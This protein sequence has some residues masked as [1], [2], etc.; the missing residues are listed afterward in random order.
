MAYIIYKTDGTVLLTLAV[1]DVDISTT[2]LDLIGK[3]VD[4]YGQ[5]SNNN[6]VRLLTNF[7]YETEPRSPQ[8][9][10]LW[11]DT[12]NARLNVYNGTAF[13]PPYGVQ[14]SGTTPTLPSEGDLWYDTINSQLKIRYGSVYKVIGPDV[15]ALY[16]KFGISTAPT[17]LRDADTDVSQDVGV[18][19][20]YGTAVGLL[21]D[22]TFNMTPADSV[23]YFNTSTTSTVVKGITALNDIDIKGDL[24]INGIRQIAP[25]QTLTTYYDVSAFGDPSDPTNL[26][27][28]N[29]AIGSFLAQVFSTATNVA[30]NEIAYPLYSDARVVCNYNSTP[31]VRR[32]QL[33]IDPLHPTVS[34]WKSYDVYYNSGIGALTNIVVI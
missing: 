33:I 16:G 26:E 6:L 1:G 24:Y 15:S 23:N 19:Y 2:S 10:Q 32:F 8:I 21:T 11:Y 20:S 28:G 3:N 12:T 25:I 5:Y 13:N 18:M 34:I 4:N 31:S 30:H 22:S 29:I 14:V 27:T 9:G 7:A 17:T